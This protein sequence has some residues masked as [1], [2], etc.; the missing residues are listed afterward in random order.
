MSQPAKTVARSVEDHRERIEQLLRPL[1]TRQVEQLAL[2]GAR[3]RML[4]EDVRSPLDLPVFRNSGMD[5]YAVRAESVA[6]TPVTLPVAGVVAAGQ[7]GPDRLPDGAAVK[8][9][10]GAP[11]PP[12]A[13]CVVPV[14]D[15]RAVDGGV[16][17]ERGRNA[18]D[19]VR[20]AG[21]DI[22]RG[23]LLV[24]AGSLLSP[25]RIAALAAVGISSVTAARRIRAAVLTTGDELVSAGVALRPG[26]IYN[27]NGIA[28]AAAL[29][30]NGIDVVDV[31]H[32][33]DDPGEFRRKLS[34]AT[35]AADVVFTSGGVSQGDFEVVKEVLADFGGE[36]G[37]VAVQPGGPQGVS[38]VDGIPI[39]SFPGNP[40]S[41]MV[42][43]EVFARPILRQLSGLAP[44]PNYEVALLDPVRSP[45][46]RR[47]F[48]RGRREGA[49]VRSVSGPGS[50][51]VA[52]MA[53]ADVLIEIPAEVTT[54]AA[55][56]LVRVREL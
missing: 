13:D 44:V 3:G 19:F 46:G 14:E 27:S 8:V 29:G 48:L 4:A 6:V 35:A 16:S 47:Q 34:V 28:L 2:H 49:G 53:Q 1:A 41:T 32:S 54:V 12:G 15:T 51:L 25:H 18:G 22:R 42:S 36:F 33:R 39:L 52:A 23:E 11:I 17:I 24:A 10:T 50:H 38:V 26:Q 31:S 40:V 21:T 9:M 7:G 55:G 5:G 30:A 45:A 56:S 20:E 43:F 37:S